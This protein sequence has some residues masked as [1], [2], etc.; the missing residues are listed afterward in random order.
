MGSDQY[1]A[2]RVYDLCVYFMTGTRKG[3]TE[4]GLTEKPEID[5]ATPGLQV[6]GLSP[7]PRQQISWKGQVEIMFNEKRKNVKSFMKG[8]V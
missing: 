5:P 6:I 1:S 7:I 8:E 3:S 4:S 2:G